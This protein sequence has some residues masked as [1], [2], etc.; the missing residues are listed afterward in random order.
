MVMDG[1]ICIPTCLYIELIICLT[2]YLHLFIM[3]P[4]IAL[5]D[6]DSGLY[7]FQ[8]RASPEEARGR[9]LWFGTQEA[10][11]TPC[12]TMLGAVVCLRPLQLR[13]PI[14]F[15]VWTNSW[16]LCF[17]PLFEAPTKPSLHS[18]PSR[19]SCMFYVASRC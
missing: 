16:R 14:I 19:S 12:P 11:R 4:L 1:W 13:N 6:I 15:K 18:Q 2:D 8:L 17:F 10:L 7:T 9:A 3:V 5:V